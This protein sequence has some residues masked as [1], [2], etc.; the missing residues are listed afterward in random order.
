MDL[1]DGNMRL[2]WLCVASLLM[3]LCLVP[4]VTW[5]QESDPE[6]WPI[7]YQDDFE[8]PSSGW[9]VEETEQ[10][11][12]AYVDGTYE[13]AIR[14]AYALATNC[15]PKMDFLDFTL[16]VDVRV[17]TESSGYLGVIYRR[18]NWNNYYMFAI[19]NYGNYMLG[20][21]KDG[22]LTTL[23]DWTDISKSFRKEE[24]N[25]L[26][27]IAQG[28]TF[29]F[30]LNGEFLVKY[31]DSTLQGGGVCLAASAFAEPGL[32]IRFD[33]LVIRADPDVQRVLNQAHGF[34]TQAQDS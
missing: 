31:T 30:F 3:M 5:A 26:R 17:Q 12:T 22:N 7:V 11:A 25:H 1:E 34:Y 27:L 29:S 13:I 9:A 28:D 23:V 6:T 2:R 19:S 10:A 32:A 18:A 16:D 20:M 8:D 21:M 4:L 33:N 15:V 14:K 24:V